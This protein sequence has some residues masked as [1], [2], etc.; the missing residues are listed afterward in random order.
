MCD[1]I[2][3]IWKLVVEVPTQGSAADRDYMTT[4]RDEIAEQL[5]QNMEWNV[6]KTYFGLIIMVVWI[7]FK[8]CNTIIIYILVFKNYFKFVKSLCWTSI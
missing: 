8:Y 2:W 7:L 5:M 1:L 4:L 6:K 3:F